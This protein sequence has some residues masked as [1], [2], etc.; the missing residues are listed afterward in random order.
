MTESG[1]EVH[2]LKLDGN[3]HIINADVAG[4]AFGLMYRYKLESMLI[5]RNEGEEEG[6]SLIPEL[7]TL[8]KVFDSPQALRQEEFEFTSLLKGQQEDQQEDQQQ[9]QQRDQ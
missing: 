2:L 9:Y 6:E 3:Q 4:R 1:H 7:D 5:R 8:V